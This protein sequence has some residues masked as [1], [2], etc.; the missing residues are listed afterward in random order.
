MI[1][2]APIGLALLLFIMWKVS[3]PAMKNCRWRM[4]HAR[5]AGGQTFYHCMACGAETLVE[6]GKTPDFCASTPGKAG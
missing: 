4:D 6:P 5:D 2:L 3:K 1:F